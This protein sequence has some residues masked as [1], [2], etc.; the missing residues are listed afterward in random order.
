MDFLEKL[1]DKYT[2][3]DFSTVTSDDLRDGEFLSF[4]WVFPSAIARSIVNDENTMCRA[5]LDHCLKHSSY[6]GDGKTIK[7][8]RVSDIE[9][10]FS[11]RLCIPPALQKLFKVRSNSKVREDQ[12]TYCQDTEGFVE[13]S[14]LCPITDIW[15]TGFISLTLDSM[16]TKGVEFDHDVMDQ[17]GTGNT[18]LYKVQGEWERAKEEDQ[19]AGPS[20]PSRAERILNA[21][22]DSDAGQQASNELDKPGEPVEEQPAKTA[23]DEEFTVFL[24]EMDK[25]FEETKGGGTQPDPAQPQ[26]DESI[27]ANQQGDEEN[28]SADQGHASH[29]KQRL[30]CGHQCATCSADFYRFRG[31]IYEMVGHVS[32]ES[33]HPFWK[34]WA[35]SVI[36]MTA[37]LERAFPY[38]AIVGAFQE[39]TTDLFDQL[40]LEAWA[41]GTVDYIATT[42]IL[43]ISELRK[44]L[45]VHNEVPL[46]ERIRS[47]IEPLNLDADL[48]ANVRQIRDQVQALLTK[49]VSLESGPQTFSINTTRVDLEPEARGLLDGV[50]EPSPDL[51]STAPRSKT[52]GIPMPSAQKLWT[53]DGLHSYLPSEIKIDK[54]GR[55][56]IHKIVGSGADSEL[57][58]I[59]LD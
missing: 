13:I 23:E 51:P 28:L 1:I 26:G 29:M 5:F 9:A 35:P 59:Y 15:V 37:L 6:T 32:Q 40:A 46:E 34:D 52:G 39:S 31:G 24:V 50:F 2:P 38:E 54:H 41:S 53:P 12:I 17:V 56:F 36:R 10:S 18:A 11:P 4:F 45:V 33:S 58:E 20:D 8:P 48:C 14:D 30:P 19:D 49:R 57:Q 42:A 47:A 21:I 27:D 55:R 43:P 16:R 25:E 3:F 7:K 22:V 44:I